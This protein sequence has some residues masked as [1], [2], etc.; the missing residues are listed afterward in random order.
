[1]HHNIIN[2]LRWRCYNIGELQWHFIMLKTIL[3]AHA[4]RF[5]SYTFQE[6]LY[7]LF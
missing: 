1:M 3:L 6:M 4:Y 5:S 7:P 2:F